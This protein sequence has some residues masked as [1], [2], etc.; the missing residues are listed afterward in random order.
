MAYAWLAAFPWGHKVDMRTPL[1][2]VALRG[3]Q[4]YVVG[5]V[6]FE[7]GN[8][9]GYPYGDRI[10]GVAS[11]AWRWRWPLHL[12]LDYLAGHA[13]AIFSAR[14]EEVELTLRERQ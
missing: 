12:D 9:R 3:G 5:S 7:N 4:V 13:C 8:S 10:K 2:T 14:A 6:D 1:A 11:S